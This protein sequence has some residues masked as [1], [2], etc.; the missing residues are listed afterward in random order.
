MAFNMAQDPGHQGQ[1]PDSQTF[2]F[3]CWGK[4]SAQKEEINSTT[5]HSETS[6]LL[7]T[8]SLAQCEVSRW[9]SGLCR[10]NPLSTQ[11]DKLQVRRGSSY[12]N[13]VTHRFVALYMRDG[14]V[15]RLD[16]SAHDPNNPGLLSGPS[17]ARV[18]RV[19]T[20]DELTT[21]VNP[22]D[23]EKGTYLEIEVAL[24]G[25]V[26][27]WVVLATCH[28]ISKD[29]DAQKYDLWEHNCFFFSWTILMVASRYRLDIETP[30]EDS[31][32]DRFANTNHISVLTKSIVGKGIGTFRDFALEA[33]SVFRQKVQNSEEGEVIRKGMSYF[34]RAVW[35]LPEGVL[36][37][38]GRKVLDAGLPMGLQKTLEANAKRVLLDRA[39]KL[40]RQV[41]ANVNPELELRKPLWVDDLQH[42]IRS[43]V[44][45][46]VIDLLWPAVLDG[47]TEGF[48]L[49]AR[50][51][52]LAKDVSAS[53][54]QSWWRYAGRRTV[55]L[56]AVETAAM[57]GG[58]VSVQREVEERAQQIRQDV[59]AGTDSTPMA[60][61]AELR[62]LN[63]KMFDLA[64]SSA[65][66]GALEFAKEA[67][68]ET[69]PSLR[70]KHREVRDVM[71]NKVWEVWD[72]CWNNACPKAREKALD[73]LDAVVIEVLD[74]SAM[75]VLEEL[76]SGETQPTV[77]VHTPKNL[78]KLQD[79]VLDVLQSG[80]KGRM[81]SLQLQKH[82]Q[83]VMQKAKFGSP[84]DSQKTMARI[85]EQVRESGDEFKKA[86]TSAHPESNQAEH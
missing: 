40:Y 22:N 3:E 17:S 72:E 26:D 35:A 85:W 21:Y 59:K 18:G 78:L 48:G 32:M 75:I 84:V 58:L 64:W 1:L 60:A 33:V 77:H 54:A 12:W 30:S 63:E 45:K 86:L 42:V 50:A 68:K 51:S 29:T 2:N 69:A 5:S 4:P 34:A 31:L 43:E 76:R 80:W 49:D 27:L 11:I 71:W 53:V 19:S 9:Y 20:T 10:N 14:S 82:M 65:R 24:D 52:E 66:E 7:F 38:F 81:T 36:E 83:R 39:P 37:F 61:M 62:K 25:K 67:V 56:W 57:H 6:P 70:L 15:H 8:E 28:A 23:L 16:R 44:Q 74:A 79:L 46:E 41:L 73:T 13:K 55:Q 47:I